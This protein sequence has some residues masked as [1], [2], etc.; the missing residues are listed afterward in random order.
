MKRFAFR[1]F[2]VVMALLVF[3]H[4]TQPIKYPA[5]LQDCPIIPTLAC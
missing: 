4:R 2:L 3:A 1:A 5:Q